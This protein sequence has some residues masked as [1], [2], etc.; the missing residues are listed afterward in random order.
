M[1]LGISSQTYDFY[2]PAGLS[3]EAL[4]KNQKMRISEFIDSSNKPQSS[5]ELF[6]LVEEV[7]LSVGYDRVAY[8]TLNSIA[9]RP[10]QAPPQPAVAL[11]YPSDWIDHYFTR[12]YQEIDPVVQYT[13]Q[14][15][16][17]Y[18]WSD[19]SAQF[20][21]SGPQ[22]R[23]LDEAEEAGLKKGVSVPVHGP[24]GRVS[25]VSFAT[26]YGDAE[27]RPHMG[28]FNA[29]GVQFDV[30]YN[31]ANKAEKNWDRAKGPLSPRELECLTWVGH[32]KSSWDIGAILGIS[33]NTVNFHMKQILRKLGTSSRTVA[34]VIAIR[35]GLIRL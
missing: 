32:G 11:N 34:V 14:I 18:R 31:S 23:V 9:Y 17:A 27:P 26:S 8:G 35:S 25:V 2:P 1:V 30:A 29:I 21:L 13:P 22:K 4:R 16:S 3:D 7:A 10:A 33:E 19:L 6:H 24:W 12:N 15:S 20:N 5:A 28:W